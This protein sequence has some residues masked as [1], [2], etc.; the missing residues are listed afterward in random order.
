[1]SDITN[2]IKNKALEIDKRRGLFPEAGGRVIVGVSGGAD[3]SCLLHVLRSLGGELGFEVVVAHLNHAARGAES[4]AD[5]R[6]VESLAA[7]YGLEFVVDKLRPEDIVTAKRKSPEAAWRELRCKFLHDT[8]RAKKASRVA[9]GHN[10]DDQ[11]ETILLRLIRGSSPTG[12]LGMDSIYGMVIRPLLTVSRAEI[13][14]YCEEHKLAFRTDSTNADVRFP[15]NRVRHRLIPY[16]GEEFNPRVRENI[17]RFAA[18]LRADVD[19]IETIANAALAEALISRTDTRIVLNPESLDLPEPMLSRVL[20]NAA[21]RILATDGWRLD[22]SHIEAMMNIA[23]TPVAGRAAALPCN[24]VMIKK[25]N[26]IVIEQTDAAARESADRLE[27]IESAILIHDGNAAPDGFPFEFD[28]N[29]YDVKSGETD[30]VIKGNRD[31]MTAYFDRDL[32][33]DSFRIRYWEKGDSFQ[34][35]GM[36]GEKLIS[37]FFIDARIDRSDRADIPLLLSGDDIVWVAGKRISHKFR[38]TDASRKILKI[39]AKRIKRD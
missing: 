4:D 20:R 28:M 26:E 23:Q 7:E 27:T 31:P 30:A 33:G 24:V 25:Y 36:D 1:M 6:F 19:F 39:T 12:I 3:S 34:P 21:L 22:A 16:L 13:E 11:A 9:L 15:R 5:A 35:L 2:I 37:D 17:F 32:L 38:F 10:A 29:I 18:M 8:A 14:E